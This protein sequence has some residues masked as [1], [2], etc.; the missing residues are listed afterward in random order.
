MKK[1]SFLLILALLFSLN[2]LTAQDEVPTIE[3]LKAIRAEKKK[4]LDAL[5]GEVSSLDRQIKNFPGWKTGAFGTLGFNLASFNNWFKQGNP[6]STS[7]TIAINLNGFANYDKDRLFWRNSGNL[8]L[9]WQKL[10]LDKSAEAADTARFENVTDVLRATSLVGYKVFD[11]IAVS[12]LVEYNTS[13]INGRFNNPGILD[14]GIG[15]TWKPIPNLVVVAHP[16]NAHIIM[17]DN[18]DFNSG[19]GAKLVV[20]YGTE[21]IP[22]LNWKTNLTSFIPYKQFEP[23]IFE[24]TW[25]NGLSYNI[26]K[27]LGIGLD[28]AIRAAD[29]EIPDEVQNYWVFGISYNI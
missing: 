25:T 23:S 4:E 26:W 8:N 6:N 1:I 10:V 24:Y 16:L 15:A 18:P 20:D 13:V 3:E 14:I 2:T 22:G 19:I 28:F 29:F 21:I 12:G 5:K 11:H 27:G 17:G 7:S 9:G